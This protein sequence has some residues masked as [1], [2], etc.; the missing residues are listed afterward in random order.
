MDTKAIRTALRRWGL[1]VRT[2]IK[3]TAAAAVIGAACGLVGTLFHFGVHEVTAF[4]GTHPWVLYLLPLA[5]LV[6]V[7]FY[8]LTGTD[9]LGTD[10]IIDAVHQGKLLP[11]LLLPAIFFGTILTHLCGGSAGREGAALQMGGTIGQYLGRHFQLDDRDLRVAT[12]AGMAAFFSALF[13][14]PLAATVFAIMVISIGVI[15]HVALYPSL[16]AALVAYGVSIHLGVE[17]TR[18]A[19]SVPEQ[20]VG[21]FVRV[22]LLGVL[23]ALVSILFCQVMHGAGHLMKR[24]RNPWLRV[25]CGGAAII[26]LTLIFGT[27]YNGAGMEIVTAA[28]EQGTVAVP[29]AFL[30][31]LIFTA[32]TLAAGFKG[33]E[34]VPSFFVGAT[35]GC[36]AAPLLGL[37]AG[38]GAAVGLAAVFCGVT[39]CPL[40]ST[41]LAVELFGAEGLLYFALACCLSYML[42]GYQGLYSSQTILYSKLKAQFIN[43]HTN[44]HHAGEKTE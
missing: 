18:F 39:N 4:R 26:V 35:F 21:M 43:V 25:V 8:K 11:I 27:D 22:A 41:L 32:I 24:I 31:K 20:T 17:P 36:T 40:A 23:C 19:V 28:V 13:G 12:L 5:G 44:A 6:I 33:G 14:T 2:F 7:G 42:S 3:W 30:L 29:W 15:Y 9:G 37:P 16:L 38:F 10:D 1:Y 34:V